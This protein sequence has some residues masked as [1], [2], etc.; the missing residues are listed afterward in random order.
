MR[1]VDSSYRVLEA[2]LNAANKNADNG[3]VP[4]W[5]TPEGVPMAPPGSGHPI[6]HQLDSCRTPFRIAQD[7]CWFGEPRALAYLQKINAFHAQ[8]GATKLVDGYN[9]DG[10]PFAG[11]TLHLAAFVAGA[12]VGAMATPQHAAVRDDAYREIMAWEPL[13]GGS[14]YYNVSWSMLGALMLTGQFTNLRAP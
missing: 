7:Y 13:L 3:L 5:S 6:H 1:V 2:T 12:G 8:V 10:S 9:L 14:R 11:A 4:A